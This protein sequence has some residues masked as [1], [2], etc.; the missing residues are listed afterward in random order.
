M[1]PSSPLPARVARLHHPVR[2]L[3]LLALLATATGAGAAD[4]FWDA[5]GNTTAGTGN[6]GTAPVNNWRTGATYL[7]WRADSATGALQSWGTVDASTATA[8]FGGDLAG[9]VNVY[10][11]YGLSV[12]SLRFER[13]GYTITSSP[14]T[15]AG[16]TPTI[17]NNVSATIASVLQGSAGLVKTGTGQLSL[18]GVNT[19]TGTTTVN[20]G[21]L[22]LYNSCVLNGTT[23]V[24]VNTGGTLYFQA[25]ERVNNAAALSIAGGTLQLHSSGSETVGAVS[26]SNDGK[27]QGSSYSGLT[28]GTTFELQSGTVGAMLEGANAAVGLN[29][30]TGGTVTLTEQ[31]TFSGKTTVSGGTLVLAYTGYNV[32]SN[33]ALRSTSEVEI[34][35]GGTVRLGPLGNQINDAAALTINGGTFHLGTFS[36]T[37]GKVTLANGGFIQNG[38]LTSTD[39]FDLRDGTVNAGLAGTAGLTKTTGGTVTLNPQLNVPYTYTG[40]TSVTGG[41]LVINGSISASAVETNRVTVGPDAT[42]AGAGSIIRPFTLAGGGTIA[43]GNPSAGPGV[44]TTGPQTW[45]A[46]SIAAFRINNTIT[47]RLAITGTL[48]AGAATIVLR[49]YG[50]VPA[51]LTDGS[52]TL[53][54]TT[55]GIT[56]FSNLALDTSA[57]GPF[58]GQFSLGLSGSEANLLLLYSAVPEPSTCALLCGLAVLGVAGLARRRQH[59]APRLR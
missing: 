24:V 28:S 44:L 32:R 29:K 35:T 52:W 48:T 59:A 21:T 13:A 55:G 41:T 25:A 11:L 19:Y 18:T 17:T 42:V 2:R 54:S 26:L 49:D 36:E 45:E 43:P 1:I 20:G 4:F 33:Y 14:L 22:L 16:T 47:D 5:D 39:A 58:D 23:A 57:L 8:V 12:N 10:G 50:L 30:T 3:A 31:N 51:T 15:L 46:G 9:S 7:T 6:S 40:A 53:A 37:V 34:N 38:R 27:I 56:G